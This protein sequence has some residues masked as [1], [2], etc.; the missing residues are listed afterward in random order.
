MLEICAAG[1]DVS[2][3][4]FPATSEDQRMYL[5]LGS[6]RSASTFSKAPSLRF[7]ILGI[8]IDRT[9]GLNPNSYLQKKI[10]FVSIEACIDTYI[11]YVYVTSPHSRPY[12]H[13]TLHVLHQ[14]TCPKRMPISEIK[15]QHTPSAITTLLSYN[16]TNVWLF[17]PA[18]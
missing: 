8:K 9:C 6:Y 7:P 2:T 5:E 16:C 18:S 4:I 1:E 17:P 14:N 15:Y 13:N 11:L 12:Y 3:W 10:S